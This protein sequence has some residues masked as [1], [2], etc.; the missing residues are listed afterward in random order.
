MTTQKLP[1]FRCRSI[2]FAAYLICQYG[3]SLIGTSVE[4]KK[5]VFLFEQAEGEITKA[6]DEF[7]GKSDDGQIH[8]CDYMSYVN[9]LKDV[10]RSITKGDF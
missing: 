8:I 5:V 4:N 3:K 10:A 2:Y 7:T 9:K 6:M 1:E